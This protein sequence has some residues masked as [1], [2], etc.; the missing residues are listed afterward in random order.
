MEKGEKLVGRLIG[1]L[2]RQSNVYFQ[3]KLRPFAIGPS[4]CKA[5]MFIYLNEKIIPKQIAEYYNLDKG[6]V[7]S[8]INGLEKN[9]FISKKSHPTDKRCV[10]LQLTNKGIEIM[11]KIKVVFKEWSDMLLKDMS[12]KEKKMLISMLG[13]MIDNVSNQ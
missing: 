6:S 5:L 9:G 2:H 12:E 10:Y 3:S 8:L 13:H 11:P 7:T 4:Q 1:V